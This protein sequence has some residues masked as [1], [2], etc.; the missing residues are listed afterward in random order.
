MQVIKKEIVPF[1]VDD[2]LVLWNIKRNNE[3]LKIPFICPYEGHVEYCIPHT[4]HIKALK[5]HHKKGDTVIVW[6]AGGWAWAQEAVRVLGLDKY[7]DF[8]MDKPAQYYD[9]LESPYWMENRIWIGDEPR[10]GSNSS[11]AKQKFL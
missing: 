6:S 5:E 7:V 8:V 10:L 11:K 3:H 9:D 2:T 1:D 4:E